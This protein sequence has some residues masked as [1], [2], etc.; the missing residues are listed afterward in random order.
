MPRGIHA[1]RTRCSLPFRR[2]D[3]DYLGWRYSLLS[4][5]A[6][7]GWNNVLDM[8]PARDI[9]EFRNF[10]DDDRQWF[11]H[12][13]DW[14]RREQ[15][16]PAQ[17]ADRF[18][19]SPRSARSTAPARSCGDRGYRVPVQPER[20][21]P[22][23]AFTLDE[24]IGLPQRGKYI[25][26]EVVSA[27][28]PAGRASRAAA[29]GR[30]A[31]T[32]SRR[33]GRRLGDGAGDRTRRRGRT[34]LCCSTRPA[35]R[36]W[37]AET[38]RL[39]GLRGEAGTTDVLAGRRAVAESMQRADRT[40][41]RSR[42]ASSSRDWSKRPSPSRARRFRHYQQVDTYDPAFHRRRREG[43]FPHPEARL[44]PTATPGARRGRFRGRRR[45]TA[46]PGWCPSGC[47]CSSRSPSRTTVGPRR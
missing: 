31:T 21:P 4:S 7:A 33:D 5:I 25:L 18:W 32:V 41:L 8:I 36:H 24:T 39:S 1:C 26:R 6:I 42:S 3:W 37:T 16:V 47:C 11:Q 27:G 15:R 35:R 30:G 19:G 34:S 45:T 40:R 28:G 44:R 46:A 10:S 9:D 17:Y 29:S 38:L 14:T 12:W 43:E 2:R 23:A 13:I 22:E 20:P